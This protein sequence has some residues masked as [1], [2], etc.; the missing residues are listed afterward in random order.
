MDIHNH[1]QYL[2]SALAHP[3]R[4]DTCFMCA[5]D[6]DAEN[7]TD[8]HVIPKWMQER[9]NLWSEELVLINGTSIPYRQLKIPCCFTCNNQRLS[10]LE[11]RIKAAFAAGFNSVDEL[12]KFDL[13]RWLAKIYLGIQYKQLSLLAD[14]SQPDMGTILDPDFVRH[15]A[16]LHFWLQLSTCTN[17]PEYAPGSVWIFPTQTP[18][19]IDLQFD[20][21]DDAT[22]GVIAIRAGS[23]GVIADFLENGVHQEINADRCRKIAQIELHPQQF[24]ELVAF[25]VYEAGLLG[26]RSEV[27]FFETDG[28]LEYAIEWWSTVEGDSP[29][30]SFS[31]PDYARI[32]SFYTGI[33]FDDL[34]KPPNLLTTWLHDPKG[35]IVY[36]PLGEPHPFAGMSPEEST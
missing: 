7:Q 17:K 24:T 11:N 35:N 26:Q 18:A 9:F 21:K 8:E 32:L 13:F 29:M 12:P 15:Y 23:V 4:P 31:Q 6:L 36:W 27:N 22:N 2:K 16:I 14:R 30:N 5:A 33:P 3:Y 25:I 10:P 19:E 1:G 34:Y 20:L 28:K